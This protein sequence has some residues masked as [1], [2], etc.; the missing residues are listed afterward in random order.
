[1]QS[2]VIGTTIGLAIL[3]SAPGSV[4]RG[5][6]RPGPATVDQAILLSEFGGRP[7]FSPDGKQ[8]AFV[9][10]SYGD[11]YE[12][13]LA[14]RKVRNLTSNIPHNGVV[15]IQYLANGDYLVTAPRHDAGPNTRAHLELWVLDKG[16]RKGLQPL[17]AH[18][19]EGVALSLRS[20]LIAWTAIEPA[21]KASENWA[22]GFS[23]PTKRHVARVSYRGGVPVLTDK[24]EILSTLPA[25]CSFI[26]PQDFRN[27]DRELIYSCIGPATSKQVSISV[28][29]TKLPNGPSVVYYRQ[30]GQYAEAEGIAPGGTW[31][32]V[33]C[34]TQG[35]AALPPLDICRLD[36]VP[37]GKLTRLVVAVQPGTGADVSNSVVSPDGRWLAF[38]RSD[39]NSPDI[40]AGSGIFLLP[41]NAT[42]R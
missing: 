8:I 31:A 2:R 24:R 22:L 7:S 23:R 5:Q 33:E 16:L 4:L 10:R 6:S 13:D 40:G 27:D 37:N 25:E 36:L 35:T 3:A 20:N 26:E 1:M 21:L 12:I 15:R 18:V 17:D 11:A 19:F 29:G 38:Q 34:G 30:P 9:S 41:V 32:T 14:S 39:T 28:M 42:A